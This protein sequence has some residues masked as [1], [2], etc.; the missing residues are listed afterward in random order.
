MSQSTSHYESLRQSL[1]EKLKDTEVH[2]K[3]VTMPDYFLDHSLTCDFDPNTLAK[4]L[5]TVASRGGGEISNIHQS[6]EVGG[7][8]AICTLALG[9]L[10]ASVRP[11]M[12]T[13]PLGLSLFR[14][15]CT[16]TSVDFSGVKLT[17]WSPLMTTI[18]ELRRGKRI[19]NVMLGDVSNTTPFDFEDLNP[20]DLKAIDGAGYVGVFNWLYNL[21]G[22]NLVD[23]VFTYCRDHSTAHTFLDT[24]DPRPRIKELPQFVGVLKRGLVDV[25]GLNENEALIFADQFESGRHRSDPVEASRV[26]ADH[27]GNRV[28]LH[29]VEYS[30]SVSR[31]GVAIAPAFAITP[32]RGTGAGDSWNAGWL[33]GDSL[34]L[35]GEEGLLFANAVA[36]RYVSNP[37]RAHA[38]VANV[39]E[40]LMASGSKL[41]KLKAS[42]R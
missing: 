29:T 9:K 2:C 30:A 18:L 8:A 36:A 27:T 5:L 39:R 38:T 40:F 15:A 33:V 42:K 23:R 20:A 37:T 12:K 32:I 35:I 13:D 22:T 26:I 24:A 31:D 1:I 41:K 28:C 21:K 25:L 3:I 14:Q 16:G 19:A 34:G 4:R 11:I 17:Q 6:L 7:N 10:G